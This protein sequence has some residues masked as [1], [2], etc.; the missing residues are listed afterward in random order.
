MNEIEKEVMKIL[1][2]LGV[3][4]LGCFHGYLMERTGIK[5][6]TVYFAVGYI[7]AAICGAVVVF[8]V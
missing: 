6:P 5:E 1:I 3:S 4:L 8:W 7:S 2:L